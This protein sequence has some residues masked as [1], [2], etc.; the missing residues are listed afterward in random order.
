MFSLDMLKGNAAIIYGAG[1]V[2][3]QLIKL[4]AGRLA[5]CKIAVSERPSEGRDLLG[6]RIYGIEELEG[7]REEAVV[8]IATTPSYQ[9]EIRVTLKSLGF[10]RVYT[11][12]DVMECIYRELYVQ[13]IV[14]NKVLLSNFHGRGYGCNP[15]YIAEELRKRGGVDIVWAAD[16]EEGFPEGVRT[17]QY[18]SYEHYRELA[19]A[20]VWVDNQHKGY[21]ARKREGQFYIQTWHG[22]GPLKRIEY[23]MG[24]L[25]VSYREM[26]DHDMDM[27]DLCLSGMNF[28]T[29]QY[30]RAFHYKG[31]IAEYGCPRNDIFFKGGSRDAV[32][33]KLGIDGRKGIVLYAPTFRNNLEAVEDGLDFER[34]LQ[35][36]QE[37]DGKEYVLLVRQHPDICVC[38]G[39]RRVSE[40]I[41][42][43]SRYDDVQE[44]LWT[45]DILITD[46]SS[47]MWDFSLQRKPVYLY[48]TDVNAYEKERGFYLTFSEYPYMEVCS[49]DELAAALMNYDESGYLSDLDEFFVK[50][51]P[52]D[53]GT[54][55]EKAAK[56][57]LGVIECG[58]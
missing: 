4:L 1:G 21:L 8:I 18:G 12:D 54:A 15:K 23:D 29:K 7:Y 2:A 22:C 5:D 49:N 42:D 6:F 52:Y 37:R 11:I 32:M 16:R 17:V 48:H 14:N 57:I 53:K 43:V 10:R 31:E 36:L 26:L 13:P 24:N 3:V 46:Y 55:S 39:D 58:T 45:S 9:K 40:T 30:R 33:K 27:V 20:R 51:H 19:T 47:I 28:T 44:L 34:V 50:Y 25:P 41:L 38:G 35:V 56:R